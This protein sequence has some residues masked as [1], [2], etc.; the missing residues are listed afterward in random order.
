MVIIAMIMAIAPF[1]LSFAMPNYYLGDD[2]N[3]V[4]GVFLDGEEDID[5]SGEVDREPE[6]ERLDE[7][8]GLLASARSS[9]H[10]ST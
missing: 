3:A 5:A 7:R 1:L 10:S 6:E 2:Q 4:E 9:L 8:S